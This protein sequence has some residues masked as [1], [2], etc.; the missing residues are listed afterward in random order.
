MSNLHFGKNKFTNFLMGKGFYLVLALCLVGA[1]AAAW[2][3]ADRTLNG[4]EEQ[5]QRV[6]D[7]AQSREDMIWQVPEVSQAPVQQEVSDVPKSSSSSSQ[8]SSSSSSPEP[9]SEPAVPSEQPV[10]LPK[11]SSLA[12]VLPV[13]GEVF[14]RYSDGKL[15][16]NDTLKVWK[17][18]DGV[19]FKAKL[20]ADVACV[21]DGTVKAVREDALWGTVVEIEHAGELVSIY[22]GLGKEPKVKEGDLVTTGQIIGAVDKIPA[23]IN[24]ETHLHFEMKQGGKYVNPLEAMNKL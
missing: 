9:S 13:E 11:Q 21:Q 1:G 14:N 3:A 17:T 22:C 5:N 20:G 2:V 19:D 15:V 24:S 7:N 12:F 6:I 18:H 16:R 8:P 23:E 4:I 10:E